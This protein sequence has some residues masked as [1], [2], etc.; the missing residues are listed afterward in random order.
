M[1]DLERRDMEQDEEYEAPYEACPT[2][3]GS[4]VINPL[5]APAGWVVFVT[6]SCPMCDGT[7]DALF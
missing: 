3:K 7:G 6:T 1:D 4:G 2:C 5:T